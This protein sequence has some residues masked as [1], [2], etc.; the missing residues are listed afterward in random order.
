[1]EKVCTCGGGAGSPE[2]YNPG[3]TL[4]S[5]LLIKHPPPLS[6]SGNDSLIITSFIPPD[7]TVSK[8]PA[9]YDLID[10]KKRENEKLNEGDLFFHPSCDR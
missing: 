3:M 10:K 8:K 1:M 6:F 7:T 5:Y 9:Y 4:R 2:S